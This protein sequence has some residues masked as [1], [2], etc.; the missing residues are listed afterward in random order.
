MKRLLARQAFVVVAIISVLVLGFFAF[1]AEAY[2]LLFIIGALLLCL[3]FVYRYEA[4]ALDVEEIV[5]LATFTALTVIGRLVFATL[6]GTPVTAM[7][8]YAAC[9]FGKTT[10]FMLGVLTALVS[11]LFLGH[12]AW[13][14]YQMAA[15]G[16]IGYL[17]GFFRP[18]LFPKKNGEESFFA[19]RSYKTVINLAI[20]S[21]WGAICGALFSLITDLNSVFFYYGKFTLARYLAVISVAFPVTLEYI[22]TNVIFVLLFYQPLLHIFTRLRQKRG[23]G[24]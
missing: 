6:P 9:F 20:L 18:L 15:W 8:I 5:A 19:F 21:V 2:Y 23:V 7:L 1:L 13:T 11:N 3:P 4:K 24:M 16:I 12:G 22:I 17:S 14:P 10:G